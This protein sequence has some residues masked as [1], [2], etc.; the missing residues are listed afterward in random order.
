VRFCFQSPTN[1]THVEWYEKAID[2]DAVGVKR[3]A[4]DDVS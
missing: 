2:L 3:T 1:P 4:W